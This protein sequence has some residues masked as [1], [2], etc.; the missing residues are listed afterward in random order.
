MINRFF[1]DE[2]NCGFYFCRNWKRQ[3]DGGFAFFIDFFKLS[4][5]CFFGSEDI[6]IDVKIQGLFCVGLSTLFDFNLFF[7]DLRG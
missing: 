7:F 2:V 5:D 4:I 3:A 1:E 6:Q